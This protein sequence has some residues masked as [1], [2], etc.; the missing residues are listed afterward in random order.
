MIFR[1]SEKQIKKDFSFSIKDGIF[2]VLMNSIA[3]T[4][5]IPYLISLNATAFQVG[6]LQSF[7]LFITSFLVLISY[8]VLKNFNS[9]KHAVVVFTSLQALI[10]IP[11]AI[12]HFFFNNYVTIWL[13]ILLYTIIIGLGI[14]VH[15]IYLD[16]IRK[17]FPVKRMGF[18]IAR[19]NLILEF[20]SI[21]PIFLIGYFLDSFKSSESLIGFTIIFICAGLFRFISSRFLNRMHPT[22]DKEYILKLVKEKE[23]DTVLKSFKKIILKDKVFF[24]FLIF[25]ILSYIGIHLATSYVTYFVLNSLGYTTVQYIWWKIAFILGMV[26]S[27]SYWGYVSDKYSSIKVLQ[28][29]S[30][31]LPFFLVVPAFFYSDYSL[32]V[33]SIFAAG[34][35][36]GAFNLGVINYLYKNIKRDLIGHSSYF[37][38][39]QATAI[40]VGTLLGAWIINIA[41]NYYVSEFKALI[42]LFIITMFFRFIP[43]FYSLTLERLH[44]RDLRFFKYVIFQRPVFYGLL[45]FTSLSHEDKKLLLDL[46]LKKELENIKGKIKNKFNQ[47]K[48]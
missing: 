2:W 13:T 17:L 40:L 8:K 9:K 31:F 32:M 24:K 5:L 12:A 39:I 44:R 35:I 6:L 14:I 27:L 22:E 46:K 4:F 19:K 11:I 20:I 34:V 18:F 28:I 43:F 16:W 1:Q 33:A 36:F 42:F 30:L 25:I 41:T 23:K 48:Q 45:E 26:L 38:I 7:P 3:I 47:K 10:W 15:P 21:I 29:S 37:F